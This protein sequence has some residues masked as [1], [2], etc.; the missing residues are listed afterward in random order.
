MKDKKQTTPQE[1]IA[2][3]VSLATGISVKQIFGKTRKR[4][5][6]NARRI[7]AVIL[8]KELFMKYQAIAAFLKK[9]HAGIILYLKQHESFIQYDREYKKLFG[10]ISNELKKID[11]YGLNNHYKELAILKAFVDDSLDKQG[12]LYEKVDELIN[13]IK[14]TKLI[15]NGN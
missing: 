13:I 12:K 6:V 14:I 8:R 10:V 2:N 1:C 4:E 15:K 7:I 11:Y 5:I 3:V 9:N